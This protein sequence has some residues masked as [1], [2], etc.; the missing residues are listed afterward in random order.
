MFLSLCSQIVFALDA[1]KWLFE[2][3]NT[4]A[5]LVDAQL[6][7]LTEYNRVHRRQVRIEAS[8]ATVRPFRKD[9]VRVL[10]IIH[11]ECQSESPTQLLP[12][13]QLEVTLVE[14]VLV[15]L[16]DLPVG[17]VVEQGSPHRLHVQ[18]AG[19]DCH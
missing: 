8:L 15:G 6:T 9:V 13:L 14:I 16:V 2:V 19:A 5:L 11:T 7:V 18:A 3:C 17:K 10:W 12:T 1:V 4:V